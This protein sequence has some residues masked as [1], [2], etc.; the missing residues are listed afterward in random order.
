MHPLVVFLITITAN[1]ITGII[2]YFILSRFDRWA[3]KKSPFK[4]KYV[5][6][7]TKIAQRVEKFTKRYGALGLA[8][9]IAIPFPGSGVYTG[10]MG[11]FILNFSK[12]KYL[13]STAVGVTLAGIIVTFLTLSGQFFFI[14]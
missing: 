1:F 11:A 2:V 6:K 10:T 8:L 14:N 4:K 13:I 9:F 7:R 5:E 12:K 3:R